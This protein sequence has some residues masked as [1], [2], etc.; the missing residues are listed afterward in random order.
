MNRVVFIGS[1][2]F[3]LLVYTSPLG[4]GSMPITHGG[5]LDK[6]SGTLRISIIP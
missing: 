1:E 4:V 3:F 6:E 2:K 5:F